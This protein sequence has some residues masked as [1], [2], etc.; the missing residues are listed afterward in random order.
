M[1]TT[2]SDN[3]HILQSGVVHALEQVVPLQ[4]KDVKMNPI[5]SEISIQY[6]VLV[7]VTGAMKGK[8]LYKGDLS[9]F[10]A[11]GEM[12][13]GMALEGDMLKSFTGEL[14]NMISG[15]LCTYVSTKDIVIDITAP[16]IMDGNSSISGFK[17]AYQL[18][19]L[20]DN[21]EKLYVAILID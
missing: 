10:R 6:G 1:T 18:S 12:M 8:I 4:Q 21:Q 11:L 17:E 7:G 9:L 14:G 3:F 5:S 13:F 16:T 19:I 2:I 20:F 15:G